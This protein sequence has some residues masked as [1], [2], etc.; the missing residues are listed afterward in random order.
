MAAADDGKKYGDP[1]KARIWIVLLL[2]ACIASTVYAFVLRAE[3]IRLQ[4]IALQEKERAMQAQEEGRRQQ[5]LAAEAEVRA[6]YAMEEAVRQQK[7]CERHYQE[8]MKRQ[9]K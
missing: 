5:M 2:I 1:I 6:H 7:E 3:I 8:M 9:K 4:E